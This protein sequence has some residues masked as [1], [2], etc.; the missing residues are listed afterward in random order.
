MSRTLFSSSQDS[1]FSLF[2]RAITSFKSSRYDITLTHTLV[3]TFRSA[4]HTLFLFNY[5]RMSLNVFLLS[6]DLLV[7]SHI[8]LLVTSQTVAM[9][10]THLTN[11]GFFHRVSHQKLLIVGVVYGLLFMLFWIS[12]SGWMDSTKQLSALFYT[13]CLCLHDAS[14]VVFASVLD[15]VLETIARVNNQRTTLLHSAQKGTLV[16]SG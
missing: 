5:I 4:M 13:L 2:S 14:S 8:A 7:Y 9:V 15:D 6:D 3:C 10:T 16:G 1:Q 12:C 11:K